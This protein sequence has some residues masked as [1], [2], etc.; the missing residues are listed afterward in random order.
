MTIAIVY[1]C[2]TS[3]YYASFGMPTEYPLLKL[4]DWIVTLFFTI[5]II[6]NFMLLRKNKDGKLRRSH[7]FNAKQYARGWLFWDVI[8]TFP[9]G[10]VMGND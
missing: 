2:I 4:L 1:A 8:A 3:A 9:F 10:P 6:F 7:I 5:D